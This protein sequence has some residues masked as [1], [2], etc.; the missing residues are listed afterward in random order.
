MKSAQNTTQTKTKP[1]STMCSCIECHKAYCAD[2]FSAYH[3]LDELRK[4]QTSLA[5]LIEQSEAMQQSQN[6]LRNTHKNNISSFRTM[7]FGFT[8]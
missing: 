8:S 3:K 1:S 7:S 4:Y 5:A 6:K 2:C